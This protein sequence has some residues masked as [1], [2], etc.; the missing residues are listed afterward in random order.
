M[1]LVVFVI[2]VLIVVLGFDKIKKGVQALKR[3]FSRVRSKIHDDEDSLPQEFHWFM[4]D[5][6]SKFQEQCIGGDQFAILFLVSESDI[7]QIRS[8]QFRNSQNG[9]LTNNDVPFWPPNDQ[10]VNYI[11]ARV[12][13][14]S[15]SGT[16]VHSEKM[17]LDRAHKL[18]ESYN[19]INHTGPNFIILFSWLMPCRHCTDNLIHTFFTGPNSAMFG[20]KKVIVAYTIDWK[21]DYNNVEESRKILKSYGAVVERVPYDERLPIA[22]PM[23]SPTDYGYPTEQLHTEHDDSAA[24]RHEHFTAQS[25]Y[26]PLAPSQWSHPI[27]IIQPHTIPYYQRVLSP[28]NL[29]QDKLSVPLRSHSDN[30][31]S[32]GSHDLR[33]RPVERSISVP[34]S[35]DLQL[36]SNCEWPQLKP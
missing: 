12:D 29:T 10:W 36:D 1:S 24:P 6:I 35:P 9:D 5:V 21:K 7:R 4:Q 31:T 19:R 2:V 20:T 30:P 27:Q 26:Q 8:T 34:S 22:Q 23:M 13:K 15:F 28:L 3:Q 25:S 16:S 17:L 33:R 14:E 32:I 18:W 11:V